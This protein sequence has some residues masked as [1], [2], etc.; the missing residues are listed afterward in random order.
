MSDKKEEPQKEKDNADVIEK[1]Y[2]DITTTKYCKTTIL[3]NLSFESELD[4]YI[5]DFLPL[6]N[7]QKE[8]LLLKMFNK[9]I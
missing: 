5:F 9:N 2:K 1:V 4:K 3:N 8:E 6:S 7:S